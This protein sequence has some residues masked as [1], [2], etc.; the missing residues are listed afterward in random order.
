VR[1]SVDV[2]CELAVLSRNIKRLTK[3]MAAILPRPAQIGEIVIKRIVVASF[4][5]LLAMSCAPAATTTTGIGPGI[6]EVPQDPAAV[7]YLNLHRRHPDGAEGVDEFHREFSSDDA[8]ERLT[9]IR[10]ILESFNQL[11]EKSRRVLSEPELRAV[12]NTDGEMQTLGFHNI[13]LIVEGTILK[14]EYRLR[15]AQFEL[16]RL[17][18]ERG[19]ITAEALNFAQKEYQ[20]ATKKFQTYWDTKIPGD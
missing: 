20:D 10:S 5:G 15:Q 12:G 19:D 3:D 18:R 2:S 6:G 9:Q 4:L 11:T 17:R 8:L 13:P 7:G 16:A 14:Q 1:K